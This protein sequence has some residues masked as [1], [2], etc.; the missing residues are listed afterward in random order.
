[1]PPPVN[2]SER[3]VYKNSLIVDAAMML[4]LAVEICFNLCFSIG[5]NSIRPGDF[6]NT[7]NVRLDQLGDR[8]LLLPEHVR[9][10]AMRIGAD[11][12]VYL[13]GYDFRPLGANVPVYIGGAKVGEHDLICDTLVRSSIAPPLPGRY[14]V[15]LKVRRVTNSNHRSWLI[16]TLQEES[17]LRTKKRDGTCKPHWW[18]TIGAQQHWAGRVLILVELPPEEDALGPH[19]IHG[20]FRL[21]GG[22]WQRFHGQRHLVAP[23]AATAK[24]KAAPKAAAAAAKAHAAPKALPKAAPRPPKQPWSDFKNRLTWKQRG[25]QRIA[26][27]KQFLNQAKK[28]ATNTRK[29]VN[30]WRSSLL[31]T[32]LQGQHFYDVD[33]NY[34]TREGSRPGGGSKMPAASE[35]ALEMVYSTY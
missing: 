9:A 5:G 13:D 23:A 26:G 1:M 4:G 30:A 2:W 29:A 10:A 19:R 17:W 11:I 22:E 18:Q 21:L 3:E 33:R 32:R 20:F 27:V 8:N 24:A 12:G 14:S 15:E 35:T 34:F 25:S 6:P 28:P 7:I 16:D 31:R